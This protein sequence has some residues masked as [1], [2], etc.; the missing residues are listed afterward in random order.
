ME[1]DEFIASKHAKTTQS[2]FDVDVDCLNAK[3]FGWQ[4]RVIQWALKRGRA[5]LFLDTG[6]GKTI[7][8]LTWAEHVC[9]HTGG[10]AVV[11]VDASSGVE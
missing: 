3:A 11:D 5:A 9:K 8:Q 6:L 10:R 4:R 7:S 1:Y 2:G